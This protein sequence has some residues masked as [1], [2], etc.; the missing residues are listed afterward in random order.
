MEILQAHWL[1]Y[2]GD[3]FEWTQDNL[4]AGS[5][6]QDIL[7]T[8]LKAGVPEGVAQLML[9]A[10][11]SDADE[12]SPEDGVMFTEVEHHDRRVLH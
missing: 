6:P 10:A 11:A 5:Q 7:E 1:D 12:I 8:L 9:Q 3:W 4:D 2:Y